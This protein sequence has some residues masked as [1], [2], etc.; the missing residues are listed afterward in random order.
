VREEDKNWIDYIDTEVR[1]A[2]AVN[3]WTH[4]TRRK[5]AAR[6]KPVSE[7]VVDD[8][9]WK[10]IPGVQTAAAYAPPTDPEAIYYVVSFDLGACRFVFQHDTSH[11]GVIGPHWEVT[12]FSEIRPRPT[13]T[14][15]TSP[16]GTRPIPAP[17][18]LRGHL[19]DLVARFRPNA[20]LST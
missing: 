9:E 20:F 16:H 11:C 7:S 2:C 13:V 14:D 6:E 4:Q 15:L 8:F 1:A 19:L 17:G 10:L 12:T 18:W 3:G 5:W